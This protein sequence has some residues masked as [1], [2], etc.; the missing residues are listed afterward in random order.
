MKIRPPSPRP[1]HE[2]LVDELRAT[3]LTGYQPGERLEAEAALAKE[4]GVSIVTLRSAMLILEHEGL[5]RRRQGSGTYVC[6]P[7]GDRHVGVALAIDGFQHPGAHAFHFGIAH[8]IWTR[9]AEA[10]HRLKLYAWCSNGSPPNQVADDEVLE[11]ARA[12]RLEALVVLRMLPVRLS[13]ALCAAGVPLVGSDDRALLR[14]EHD[15]EGLV[16]EGLRV[17]LGAGRRRI[18]LLGWGAPLNFNRIGDTFRRQAAEL[19]IPVRDEWIR[20]RLH[21]AHPGSGW[22]DFRDVWH[23]HREKPDGL[24]ICDDVLYRDA[25]IAVR[26]L[27]IRVPDELMVVTHHN[28][29]TTTPHEF[30]VTLL[31]ADTEAHADALADGTLAILRGDMPP[32]RRIVLAHEVRRT[33]SAV[34]GRQRAAST[35]WT[36][37]V[38]PVSSAGVISDQ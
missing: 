7:P 33:G 16:R 8:R 25:A 9:L 17:L 22:E 31:E 5:I 10:G 26:E 29:G 32:A 18:A 15:T 34:A 6:D 12:R 30:P 28:K 4:A 14:V 21:P 1:L 2:R 19:G 23:A 13:D 37:G 27:G 36:E 20:D 38:P 3:I 24:L 35:T 11:A